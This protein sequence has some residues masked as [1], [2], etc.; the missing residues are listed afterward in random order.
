VTTYSKPRFTLLICE[1]K[2]TSLP[3]NC[4]SLQYSYF[5]LNAVG[6]TYDA[7]IQYIYIYIYIQCN[8][9][10]VTGFVNK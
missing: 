9:M 6:L 1:D 8:K 10:Q 7:Y 3:A 4:K 5:I 2:Y